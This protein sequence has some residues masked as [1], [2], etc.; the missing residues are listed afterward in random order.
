MKVVIMGDSSRF[1]DSYIGR[2]CPNR[3]SKVMA[4]WRRAI[5]LSLG[6]EDTVTLRSIA[7]SRTEP[8]SRV[9]RARI[10]LAYREDPSFLR[11]VG[12]LDC[13]IRPFSVASSAPWLK[14]RW[15]RSTIARAPDQVDP[16]QRS[17]E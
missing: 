9:E 12:D 11:S 7:Q 4:A 15:L 1:S 6:D 14:A 13:I 17:E 2:V 5:E 10:L 16:R 8:A 3:G